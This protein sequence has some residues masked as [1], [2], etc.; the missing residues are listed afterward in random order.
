MTGTGRDSG[1]L[2]GVSL[3]ARGKG[4]DAARLRMRREVDSVA[5]NCGDESS[6]D[7]GRTDAAKGVVRRHGQLESATAILYAHGKARRR[8]I[9]L[10]G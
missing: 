8:V 6:V 5:A 9:D 1:C 4:A 3:A 2:K 7:A 10:I